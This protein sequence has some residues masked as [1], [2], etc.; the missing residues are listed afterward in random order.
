MDSSISI[1]KPIN[2]S[3]AHGIDAQDALDLIKGNFLLNGIPLV[4][5]GHGSTL[6]TVNLLGKK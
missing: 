6:G 3:Y 5:S 2:L 1:S 4:I